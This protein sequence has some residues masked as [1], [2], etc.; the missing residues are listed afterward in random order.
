MAHYSDWFPSAREAILRMV[1]AW[2]FFIATKLQAWGIPE[3]VAQNLSV[4]AITADTS[5]E[6]AKNE[7][8]RT[9]AA[10]ARCNEAFGALTAA[11]WDMKNRY[12]L[13][14]PLSDADFVAL[15]LKPCD[16]TPTLSG[17]PTAQVME[18][19]FLVGRPAGARCQSR[20][21]YQKFQRPG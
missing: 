11:M 2:L 5:L 6:A 20:L 18:E 10:T 7:P 14:P 16:T 1:K 17:T 4:L 9:P 12:F 19:P 15:G 13:T 3:C 21:R 8:I